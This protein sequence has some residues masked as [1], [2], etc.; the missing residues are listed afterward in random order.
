MPGLNWW[1]PLHFPPSCA[2]KPCRAGLRNVHT[3]GN[4][5]HAAH[6]HPASHPPCS[7][8][9]KELNEKLASLTEHN[10]ESCSLAAPVRAVHLLWAEGVLMQRGMWWSRTWLQASSLSHGPCV[11]YTVCCSHS[12]C[13]A[14]HCPKQ[15]CSTSPT[16]RNQV[17]KYMI[18]GGSVGLLLLHWAAL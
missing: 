6:A 7:E 3:P 12:L 18:T 4:L 8:R 2:A 16:Q 13:P 15:I 9:I 11:T 5:W 14:W 17:A 10:G 1:S